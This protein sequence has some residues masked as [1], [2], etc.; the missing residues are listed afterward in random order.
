MKKLSKALAIAAIA[1]S[2]T[3]AQAQLYGEVG[4][5]ALKFSSQDLA[6]KIE[7]SPKILGLTVG[8]GVLNNVAVEA[9]LGFNAGDDAAKL[10]GDASN[11]RVKIDQ[12]FGVFVKPRAMLGANLEV[13]GRLG[14]ARTTANI[15]VPG[16][17][18]SAGNNGFAYGLGANYYFN[19]KIYLT[20][21]YMN[22]YNKDES[23][24]DGFTFGLGMKF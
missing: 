15:T 20:A 10:D 13:F 16:A 21:N 23:K 7:A 22:M 4:Y 3:A 2:A 11:G 6:G 1:V 14:Y 24:V 8:Y 9:M 5:S 18:D 12:V 17:S 19:P